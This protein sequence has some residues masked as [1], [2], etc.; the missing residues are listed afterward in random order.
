MPVPA[1]FLRATPLVALHAVLV[2]VWI[3]GLTEAAELTP[4]PTAGRDHQLVTV[5]VAA[6]SHGDAGLLM[7]LPGHLGHAAAPALADP[8]DPDLY[9]RWPAVIPT[10]LARLPADRLATVRPRLAPLLEHDRA[11]AAAFDRGRLGEVLL[12]APTDPRA[13]AARELLGL[14]AGSL[15]APALPS[16]GTGTAPIALTGPLRLGDGWLFAVTAETGILWQ[17]RIER[18][19]EVVIGLTSALVSQTSGLWRINLDGEAIP[20]PHLPAFARPLAV[21]GRWAWFAARTRLWRLDLDQGEIATLDLPEAPL[22]PPVLRGTNGWWLTRHALL[23]TDG[24]T[25]TDRLPHLLALS[26]NATLAPLPGAALILD[27]PRWW[28]VGPRPEAPPATQVESLLMAGEITA[29][30]RLLATI[31]DLQ[32]SLRFRVELTQPQTAQERAISALLAAR[33]GNP[34]PLAQLSEAVVLTESATELR[35]PVAAWPHRVSLAA[36]RALDG[37]PPTITIA[38]DATTVTVHAAWADPARW[39]ERTWSTRPLLDA[40][41]R[42]W[43]LIP[44]AVVIADGADHLLVAEAQTGAVICEHSI[45]SAVDPAEVVRTAQGAAALAEGGRVLLILTRETVTRRVLPA[46]AASLT[47]R[48]GQVV[49][50]LENGQEWTPAP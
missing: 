34:G 22:G 13:T 7:A 12:L 10:A 38:A 35:W 47:A 2:S 18:Q 3:G 30:T 14:D 16:S 1:R 21:H 4:L 17:R 26:P 20:L 44:G 28:R 42:S 8:L 15:A 43:A 5:A 48:N 36:W 31:D 19:A 45:P 29:A 25:I 41:A 6:L 37:V 39:W 24:T 40:P 9:R 27:D 11:V 50:R 33:A 23:T 32:E 46:M 49:V